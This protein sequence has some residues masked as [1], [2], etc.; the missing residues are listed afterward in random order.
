MLA[1]LNHLRELYATSWLQ[2]AQW[3]LNLTCIVVICLHLLLYSYLMATSFYYRMLTAAAIKLREYIS[4]FTLQKNP[5][6]H[7]CCILMPPLVKGIMETASRHD[8]SPSFKSESG[9]KRIIST[10]NQVVM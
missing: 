2:Y 6:L 8:Q 9:A 10:A 1:R 4:H 3:Q 5:S 7:L